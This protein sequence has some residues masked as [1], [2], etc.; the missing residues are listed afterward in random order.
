MFYYMTT[1]VTC[2]LK[3]MYCYGKACQDFGNDFRDP[4]IDYDLP[5]Y[6]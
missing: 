6:N 3:Y 5:E 2:D 4:Q 1:T